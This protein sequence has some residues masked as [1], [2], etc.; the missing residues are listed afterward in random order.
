MEYEKIKQLMDDM[1]NSKLTQIDIDFP[2]GTKI[3]MK[4]EVKREKIIFS[5]NYSNSLPTS[6]IGTY[7]NRTMQNEIK[8]TIEPQKEGNIVK[9]PMV[10]TFYLK[11]SP[12]R[13][14]IC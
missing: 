9:S 10:G 14:T 7:E 2:D 1:E 6:N 12:T 5:D 13:R 4:K 11:P 8:E 3:S